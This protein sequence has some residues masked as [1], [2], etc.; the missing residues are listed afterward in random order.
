M[1]WWHIY[2]VWLVWARLPVYSD[3]KQICGIF[4][5]KKCLVVDQSRIASKHERPISFPDSAPRVC[6]YINQ[7]GGGS[8]GHMIVGF[9]WSCRLPGRNCPLFRLR[10]GIKPPRGQPLDSLEI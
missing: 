10:T 3:C 7:L 6:N 5:C 4:S 1:I 2:V 9:E 8:D